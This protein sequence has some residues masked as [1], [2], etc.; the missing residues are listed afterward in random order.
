MWEAGGLGVSLAF[1]QARAGP[2]SGCLP[3]S[4]PSL[5]QGTKQGLHLQPLILRY[6]QASLRE[7]VMQDLQEEVCP[8]SWLTSVPARH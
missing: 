5:P 2:Q 8:S 1:F 6:A 4:V 3:I 7:C